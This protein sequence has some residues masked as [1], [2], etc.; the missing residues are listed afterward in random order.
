MEDSRKNQ[1]HAK[2]LRAVLIVDEDGNQS[3]THGRT[4]DV[5]SGGASI[6]SDYNLVSKHPIT[7][8]ILLRPG[9][10]INPPLIFEAKS[11]VVHSVLSR[12]Q[13][14]FRISVEFLDI[15]GD[16]ATTLKKFLSASLAT[17]N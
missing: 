13:G 7:V 8:C 1:R 4:H 6:I 15:A 3:K 10:P 16:G 5:S 14:G 9:D 2:R 17:T 11:R 12:Q